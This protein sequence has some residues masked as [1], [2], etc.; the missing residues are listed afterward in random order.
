MPDCFPNARLIKVTFE[1]LDV[2]R[3]SVETSIPLGNRTLRILCYPLEALV[4]E[5]VEGQG[6]IL[7]PVEIVAVRYSLLPVNV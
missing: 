2:F 1:F 7:I 4:V 5:G 6:G 3:D